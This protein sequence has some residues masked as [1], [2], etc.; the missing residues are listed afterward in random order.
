[1][2]PRA[3]LDVSEKGEVYSPLERKKLILLCEPSADWSSSAFCAVSLSV[4]GQCQ[5]E[6]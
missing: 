1:V 4:S 2:V 6:R 3:G 5:N